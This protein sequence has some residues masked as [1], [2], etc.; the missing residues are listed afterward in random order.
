MKDIERIAKLV[1]S[2]STVAVATRS[3]DGSPQIAPLFYLADDNLR[4]YWFSSCSSLHSRN[5]RKNNAAA[6]TIYRSADQWRK[7]RGVQ[8][9]GTVSL[10]TDPIRRNPISGEYADR[11]HLGPALRTKIL[12]SGLFMFRPSWARYIDNGKQFGYRFETKLVAPH[13]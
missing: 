13:A 7:I 10:V 11:F 12:R 3:P 2:E 4:L 6:V 1:K 9:R 5:L 8:M